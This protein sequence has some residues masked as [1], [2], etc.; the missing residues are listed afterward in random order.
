MV[1]DMTPYDRWFLASHQEQVA[2]GLPGHLCLLRL[3]LSGSL[4]VG[5]LRAAVAA[6]I[7]RHPITAARVRWRPLS[8]RAYWAVDPAEVPAPGDAPVISWDLRSD[9]SPQRSADEILT[10]RL[11]EPQD[12]G[13]TP[14]VRL[15]HF[16]LGTQAHQVVLRW[17]HYLMDL[18]GA[19]LFM[20][21][22]AEADRGAVEGDG[23]SVPPTEPPGWGRRRIRRTWQGLRAQWRLAR[24]DNA[25]RTSRQTPNVAAASF[26]F[27]TWEAPI[28]TGLDRAAARLV[29][30]GPL[31]RT[32]VLLG[33]VLEAMDEMH[34]SLGLDGKQYVVPLPLGVP[35][36]GPRRTATMNDITIPAIVAHRGLFSEPAALD[37]E[38][39]RQIRAYRDSGLEEAT[40]RVMTFAGLL[41]GL[42]YRWMIRRTL[43]R[44]RWTVGFTHYR[45]PPAGFARLAGCRVD[46]LMACGLPPVPPGLMLSFCRY[47]DRLNLGAAYHNHVWSAAEMEALL[48]RIDAHLQ[49]RALAVGAAPRTLRSTP[50]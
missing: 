25:I 18:E 5:R 40:W 13:A 26:L 39:A 16:R 46:N 7:R 23:S 44:P 30:T 21:S 43:G 11:R 27:R 22:V 10:L 2:A 6:A 37:A 41:R 3:D 48:A 1:H 36:E 9:A 15:L 49:Q 12:P 14:Q 32:R 17:P 45:A 42:H 35:R 47:G 24:A 28:V 50:G 4:D 31:A 38:L 29:Q 19:R 20:Q 8:G 33:A 34:E